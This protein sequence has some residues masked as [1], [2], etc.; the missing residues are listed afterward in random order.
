MAPSSDFDVNQYLKYENDNQQPIFDQSFTVRYTVAF[1]FSN[2]YDAF[3]NN[4][5]GGKGCIILKLWNDINIPDENNG[6]MICGIIKDVL[7]AEVDGVKFESDLKGQIKTGR[8]FIIV[9]DYQE[10][11]IIDNAVELGMIIFC[12][13]SLFNNHREVDELPSLWISAVGSC[14][15]KLNL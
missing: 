1:L 7:L 14:I 4:P 5:W 2:K 3:K 11:Q 12:A 15:D 10:A 9:I 13:W 6:S 8:K